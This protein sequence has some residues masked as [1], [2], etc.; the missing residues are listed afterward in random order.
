MLI[1][2]KDDFI[3]ISDKSLNDIISLYKDLLRC[4]KYPARN[5]YLPPGLRTSEEL[6]KEISTGHWCAIRCYEKSWKLGRIFNVK[7]RNR[8]QAIRFIEKHFNKYL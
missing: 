8:K 4:I 3:E 6:W 5:Y 2:I 1:Y 7:I